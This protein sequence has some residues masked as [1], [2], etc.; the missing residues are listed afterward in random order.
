MDE[1][2]EHRDLRDSSCR[3]VIPYVHGRDGCCIAVCCSSIG[4]TFFILMFAWPFIA[5]G[6]GKYNVT[7]GPTGGPGVVGSM[8]TRALPAWCSK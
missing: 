6:H 3:S 7:Q 8:R 1:H 5:E 4:L 2:G